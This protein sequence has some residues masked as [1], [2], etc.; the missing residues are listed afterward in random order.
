VLRGDRIGIIGPNGAGKTTLLRLL[1]GQLSPESGE[2]RL[3][4]NLQIS[5]FDQQRATLDPE[6]TVIDNLGD[7]KDSIECNGQRRHIIGYLQDFLFTPDRARSP[8][9]V[10]SGGERNRLLLAKLFARP[11]NLLV[12]DEPTNDLDME[13]LELLEELLLDYKGTILLVSHDRAFLN[14]VATST[15]VFEG[16][17]RVQEYAGGYDDWLH[18]RPQIREG[19]TKEKKAA[20][21]LISKETGPRKLTF[22]EAGELDELPGLIEKMEEEQRQLYQ[23]LADPAFYQEAGDRIGSVKSRLEQLENDLTAAYQRWQQLES[24]KDFRLNKKK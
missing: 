3:G 2:I 20:R 4:T 7:G 1:T 15:L 8:V 13:T 19:K 5:Y 17:G 22:K 6:K 10:L 24:I 9:S 21:K 16:D 11:S 18:Q 12:L 14:N 23:I